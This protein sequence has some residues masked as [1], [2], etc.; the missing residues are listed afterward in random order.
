MYKQ[1][2]WATVAVFMRV[3]D[4]ST[5]GPIHRYEDRSYIILYTTLFTVPLG[6]ISTRVCYTLPLLFKHNII[7]WAIG[8]TIYYDD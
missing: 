7:V 1:K 2:M 6:P 8:H 4:T 3:R 5:L